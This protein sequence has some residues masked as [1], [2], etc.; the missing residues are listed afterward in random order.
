M[1]R[2]AALAAAVLLAAGAALTGCSGGPEESTPTTTPPTAAERL[3]RAKA[4]ADAAS[5]L[6]LSVRSADIPRDA[7]GV[8]ALDGVG[9]HA[10][11]FKG[12]LDARIAGAQAKVQVVAVDGDLYV[13]LPFTSIYAPTDPA[14]YGAPDPAR[15]FATTGGVT[16]L[17]TATEDPRL[18][19]K[20]RSG[21]EVLQTVTGT[22]DGDAVVDLLQAGDRQG[23]FTVRYG[24]TDPG[25]Q[26]RTAAVTG[27]FY[28]TTPSTYT[29][30][31]DRYGDQVEISKP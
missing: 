28:G 14:T 2:P 4:V 20:T 30:T 1:V 22:L 15:L 5:S 19:E 21:A 3:A 31:L 26:L 18:G 23:T 6:R 24:L 13:K 8:I 7:N 16:S 27:P 12:S 29:V 11:A 10:P 17:L 25:D 9:T